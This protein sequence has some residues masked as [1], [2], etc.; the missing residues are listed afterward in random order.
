MSEEPA[1]DKEESK[2]KD[3]SVPEQLASKASDLI[4]RS[5][6][7]L[8]K[9]YDSAK[10]EAEAAIKRAAPPPPSPPPPPPHAP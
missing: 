3:P 9:A 5:K 10:A 4:R 7:T 6:A 1:Q 2:S 8:R